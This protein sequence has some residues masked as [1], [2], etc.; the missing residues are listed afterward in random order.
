MI[1]SINLNLMKKKFGTL[2]SKIFT[3]AKMSVALINDSLLKWNMFESF[4]KNNTEE[5]MNSSLDSLAKQLGC[6]SFVF[7]EDINS[8]LYWVGIQYFNIFLNTRIPMKQIILLLPLDN[9]IDKYDLYHEMNEK[10][11]VKDFLIDYG[12][13]SVL[14]KLR[15]KS[16]ISISSLSFLTGISVNTIK[17]YEKSNKNLF[18]A[19]FANITKIKKALK[20]EESFFYEKS[21][22]IPYSEN[23][24][25]DSIFIAAFKKNIKEY[26]NLSVEDFQIITDADFLKS[27]IVSLYIGPICYLQ[28]SRRKKQIP[29]S[30]VERAVSLAVD[31]TINRNSFNNLYF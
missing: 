10:E 29:S 1:D 18:N 7:S 28:D 16:D 19:S 23:L 15:N 21:E 11:I 30:V 8:V 27:A 4:E 13:E 9:L 31:E 22:F 6:N 2:I 12:Q 5:F 24:W 20:A 3:D 26:L 17:F 25:N 14:K